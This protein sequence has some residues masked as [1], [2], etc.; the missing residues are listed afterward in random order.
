MAPVRYSILKIIDGGYT[1]D[2]QKAIVA[3]QTDQG[4]LEL[5]MSAGMLAQQIF[6]L[7][8]LLGKML[9]DGAD[10]IVPPDADGSER[11]R[12]VEFLRD[13]ETGDRVMR[14]TLASGRAMSIRLDSRLISARP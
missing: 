14:V 1:E 6:A 10:P 7:Q 4:R 9:D 12:T 2:A 3:L 11:A 8:H 13:A 5:T